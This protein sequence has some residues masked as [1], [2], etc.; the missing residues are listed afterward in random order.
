M[1]AT[2]WAGRWDLRGQPPHHTELL[3]DPCM[4]V[5]FEAGTSPQAGSRVVGVWERLWRRTLEGRGSV[6]GVKLRAGAAR[7][8]LDEPAASFSSRITPLSALLGPEAA[9]LE[10]RVLPPVE[11]DAAFE[12]LAQWLRERRRGDPVAIGLAVRLVERITT[13]PQITSVERLAE[14]AG[15]GPRALQRLF[16]E[17]VG[18]APKWVI[19]RN[20]LQEVALRIERGDALSLAGL[21]A[22]LGYADQAHMARDFKD[23]VGKS[24]REFALRVR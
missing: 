1:V 24:P 16:R 11:D 14:V 9:R 8:F 17:H 15:L 21:A 12:V 22:E 13:D 7:A 2:F 19:R 6:R 18:A 23:V 3:A 5:V 10:R 20:R 4:H